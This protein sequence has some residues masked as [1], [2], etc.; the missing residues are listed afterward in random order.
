MEREIETIETFL[1]VQEEESYML[2]LATLYLQA[3]RNKEAARLCKKMRRLF[4]NGASVDYAD[5]LLEA[6]KEDKGLEYVKNIQIIK[7]II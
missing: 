5:N 6:I 1:D 3:G 2:R 4:V 7:L